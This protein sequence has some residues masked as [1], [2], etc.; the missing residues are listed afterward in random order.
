MSKEQWG[1]A[2]WYLFHTLSHNL[3][4]ERTEL[5]EPLLNVILGICSNLPCQECSGH[6]ERTLAS[7][8]KDMIKTPRDLAE[9]MWMFHNKVNERLG[10]RQ[11][12]LTE[13]DELYSRAK[14]IEVVN[15]FM[16]VMNQRMGNERAMVHSMSRRNAINALFT[17]VKG[18]VEAFNI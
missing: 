14:L 15:H 12:T 10:A 4:P 16:A 11:M 13:H 5:V 18:N 2:S 9:V 6:A 1:R 3:K 17:F 8:R 7:L